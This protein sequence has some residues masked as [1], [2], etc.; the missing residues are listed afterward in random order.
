MRAR[1]LGT[2]RTRV[3]RGVAV[4]AIPYLESGYDAFPA[5][6]EHYLGGDAPKLHIV[7]PSETA[8][9][10]EYIAKAPRRE[11]P[12]ECVTE[13]LISRIG[14]SLPLRIAEGRLVR[15]QTPPSGE[16]DVR[17]LSRMF[18]NKSAGD[19]LEHGVELVARC[20]DMDESQVWK[21]VPT[22][23]EWSFYTVDLVDRVLEHVAGASSEVHSALRSAFA[24]MMAF[25]ALV[26][27]N[28]RHSQNWGLLVNVLRPVP[29]S[30]SPIYDTAR[31]L[32][33]NHSE[34]RL[35]SV[36]DQE[37]NRYVES[38]AERSTPLIGTESDSKPNH[39][40][41]IAYMMAPDNRRRF[42]PAVRQVIEAFKI[43][44]VRKLLHVEFRRLL[45]R[46]RLEFVEQ[47]LRFRHRRLISICRGSK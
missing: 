10:R 31:G 46:R 40:D 8:H 42:A 27:A 37:R 29:P 12:I 1:S 24:R 4:G 33:W 39:F 2:R 28:D 5:V 43:E 41:V 44:D 7:F 47:L 9:A 19:K 22:R 17:F 21:E 25:D 26:G 23:S 18:V 13:Y 6:G 35:S 32:F 16:S 20:F 38:Y 14:R 36:L 45:S 30:F 15:L 11:G 34:E 3:D